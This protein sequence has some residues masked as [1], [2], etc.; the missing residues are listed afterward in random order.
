MVRKRP[1]G[2]VTQLA[3]LSRT[4]HFRLLSYPFPLVL[5]ILPSLTS[6]A[7]LFRRSFVPHSGG[8]ERS[9]VET[10]WKD[11]WRKESDERCK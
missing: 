5:F 4:V 11:E 9:E 6:Y 1:S 3:G 2:T 10:G 7:R 8:A